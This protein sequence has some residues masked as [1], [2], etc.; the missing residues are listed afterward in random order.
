MTSI[1]DWAEVRSLLGT[2]VVAG[3]IKVGITDRC[4][5]QTRT[6]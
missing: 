4:W 1:D 5:D 6:E 2:K 3:P